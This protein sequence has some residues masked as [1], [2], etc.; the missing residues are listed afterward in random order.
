MI[1]TTTTQNGSNKRKNKKTEKYNKQINTSTNS[2]NKKYKQQHLQ[3]T[4]DMSYTYTHTLLNNSSILKI[5]THNVRSLTSPI[6]QQ[7][8]IQTINNYN[9]DIIGIAETN[10]SSKNTRYIHKSLDPNF[11]Y[12][13]SS[14]TRCKG[15]GVGIIVR[16]SIA[17]HIFNHFDYK[18]RV[19]YIDLQMKNWKKLRIIQV[20]LH[21]SNYD[22]QARLTTHKIIM[23]H[24]QQAQN[25][26][27][28]IM[29]MGDFNVNPDKPRYT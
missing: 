18:G 8:L 12:Y 3:Q 2:S 7:L 25:R 17:K 29:I 19:I 15:S 13:F 10:L 27:Y 1:N 23:E 9:I 21:T 22:I 26:N 16:S 28:E 6:T 5:A 14:D 4:D 20:Y 11:A 24:I